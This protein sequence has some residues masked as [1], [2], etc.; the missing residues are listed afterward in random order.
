M[1]N[2]TVFFPFGALRPSFAVLFA[3]LLSLCFGTSC[4]V[5]NRA[6]ILGRDLP[7]YESA[8]ITSVLL[9]DGARVEFVRPGARYSDSARAVLGVSARIG[10][11]VI[12]ADQILEAALEYDSVAADRTTVML[13][14]V[15][16]VLSLLAL[17]GLLR[18]LSFV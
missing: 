18:G 15:V 1:P 4:S 13:A 3:A 2:K 6:L 8:A 12:P 5:T 9:R 16:S 14:C 7:R 10:E 17:I 11:A